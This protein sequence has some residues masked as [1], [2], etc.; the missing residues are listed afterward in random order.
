MF[1]FEIMHYVLY[2]IHDIVNYLTKTGCDSHHMVS[3]FVYPKKSWRYL[4]NDSHSSDILHSA[5]FK[6]WYGM[7]GSL[8]DIGI[9]FYRHNAII[10]P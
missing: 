4:Q 1:V 8:Y 10:M 2:V 5:A 3:L 9:H 6:L 7:D